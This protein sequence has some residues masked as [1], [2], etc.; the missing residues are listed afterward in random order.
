MVKEISRAKLPTKFGNFTVIAFQCEAGSPEHAVLLH[1]D[2]NGKRGVP[3]RIHSECLT[4]DALGSL[5]CDCGE[6]LSLSLKFIQS[7][8]NGI[9]IYLRQ[10]GRGIGFAN[11]IKAYSLQDGG[12]DTVEANEE[13]GFANDTRDYKDAATILNS[14]KVKSISLLTNNPKKISGL[15][16][17]GIVIRDRVPLETKPNKFDRGYLEAK[18]KKLGHTLES[19]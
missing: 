12:L 9:L 2:V 15:K 16:T 14:L 17:H 3:V 10:E 19:V 8:P 11:K 4:G 7:K 13:L 5:K 6:Q 18:K 1:G